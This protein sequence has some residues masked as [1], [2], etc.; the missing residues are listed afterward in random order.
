MAGCKNGAIEETRWRVSIGFR[1]SI[2]ANIWGRHRPLEKEELTRSRAQQKEGEEEEPKNL[3]MDKLDRVLGC[4][5]SPHPILHIYI[6]ASLY[7]ISIRWIGTQKKR[8]RERWRTRREKWL[9]P[10]TFLLLLLLAFIEERNSI[11]Q[12][13]ADGATNGCRTG[14]RAF[15][16]LHEALEYWIDMMQLSFSSFSII[17]QHT[18]THTY[19][20]TR[21]L[22]LSLR[23]ALYPT[24]TARKIVRE[25]LCRQKKERWN[26]IEFSCRPA[27]RS[28]YSARY[29]QKKRKKG[30]QNRLAFLLRERGRIKRRRGGLYCLKRIYIA[31][32][33]A[34]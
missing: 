9:L 31:E 26:W 16:R 30:E 1:R 19:I 28:Y 11:G 21:S 17:F 22:S 33:R 6:Y 13:E 25:T 34:Y 15:N 5:G 32:Y 23:A 8:E 20:Y 7:Y 18:R 27:C 29:T 10:S 2:K 24:N 4:D 12:G 14:R 3:A